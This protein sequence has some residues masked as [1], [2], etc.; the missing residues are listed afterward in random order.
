MSKIRDRIYETHYLVSQHSRVPGSESAGAGKRSV[1]KLNRTAAFSLNGWLKS[2]ANRLPPKEPP[3]R[4]ISRNGVNPASLVTR[5]TTPPMP[6][7]PKIMALGPFR[8]K[9][10]RVPQILVVPPR[11]GGR[12]G[13][14]LGLAT[15]SSAVSRST[16]VTFFV[17]ATLGSG[18][19]REQDRYRQAPTHPLTRLRQLSGR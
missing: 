15:R 4:D 19:M 18:A 13:Q 5:L 3:M 9:A 2:V 12:E 10:S 6:P 7:R 14:T 8:A 1:V 17:P 11:N 16:P